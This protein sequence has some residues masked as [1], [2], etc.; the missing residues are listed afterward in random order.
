MDLKKLFLDDVVN[1]SSTVEE[2]IAEHKPSQKDLSS[3]VFLLET[4]NKVSEMMSDTS[5]SYLTD[6]VRHTDQ[7]LSIYDG[8]PQK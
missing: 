5:R 8:K 6:L 1:G 3:V 7:F 2:F 4:D